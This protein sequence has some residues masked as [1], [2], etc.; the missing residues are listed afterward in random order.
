MAL[1]LPARGAGALYTKVFLLTG[2][3]RRAMRY[4]TTDTRIAYI[5]LR[6]AELCDRF[7]GVEGSKPDVCSTSEERQLKRWRLG[8]VH[9]RGSPAILSMAADA[10]TAHG[11]S[12]HAAGCR[13]RARI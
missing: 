11:P 5:R 6:V 13:G 9:V 8:Y 12:S 7:K 10:P 4:T 1:A 2:K 3:G